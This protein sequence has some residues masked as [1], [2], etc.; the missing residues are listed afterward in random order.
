MVNGMSTAFTIDTTGTNRENICAKSRSLNRSE[1]DNKP[2]PS[3]VIGLR[4]VIYGSSTDRQQL[5][6]FVYI[7]K[8]NN[9]NYTTKTR[10]K[11]K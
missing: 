7:Y 9:N 3:S 4:E 10:Y 2:N 11:N 8:K 1:Y 5:S 6:L